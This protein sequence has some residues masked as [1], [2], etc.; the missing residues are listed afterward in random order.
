MITLNKRIN[1]Y[2]EDDLKIDIIESIT[3]KLYTA[4]MNRVDD[5]K[6]DIAIR[7]KRILLNFV[8]KIFI[9][10]IYIFIIIIYNKYRKL[11]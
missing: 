9:K 8:A 7:I 4:L 2:Y 10:S 6:E 3:D 1:E 11:S 5:D